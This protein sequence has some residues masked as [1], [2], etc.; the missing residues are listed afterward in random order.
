MFVLLHVN[1]VPLFT[2][3]QKNK[4]QHHQQRQLFSFS[5]FDGS[6]LVVHFISFHFL[7]YAFISFHFNAICYHLKKISIRFGDALNFHSYLIDT[8]K[9]M[10][11]ICKPSQCL[12]VSAN[13]K[14]FTQTKKKPDLKC[15]NEIL[16]NCSSR[17]VTLK[18]FNF[19]EICEARSRERRMEKKLP[20]PTTTIAIS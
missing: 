14:T 15:Q 12:Q 16:L 10:S 6:S 20:P 7:I 9:F 19:D 4:Q 17:N 2:F 1:C 3:N 11:V 5:I 18:S 13:K 8:L